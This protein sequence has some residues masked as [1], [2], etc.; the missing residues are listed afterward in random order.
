MRMQGETFMQPSKFLASS[1]WKRVSTFCQAL[2]TAQTLRKLQHPFL[3][4]TGKSASLHQLAENKTHLLGGRIFSPH[5]CKKGS[6]C[7][8]VAHLC[9]KM[10]HRHH[11]FHIGVVC[12]GQG[13]CFFCYSWWAVTDLA[14]EHG[15]GVPD[16]IPHKGPIPRG[17]TKTLLYFCLG[18]TSILIPAVGLW[19]VS[20]T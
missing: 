17:S 19:L 15:C 9:F 11:D 12:W 18:W 13:N 2:Q 14:T 16:R 5:Y 1:S 6:I 20:P 10:G 8:L 4:P 3:L 7:L